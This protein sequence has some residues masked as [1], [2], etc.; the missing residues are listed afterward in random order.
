MYTKIY[1][2]AEDRNDTEALETLKTIGKPPYSRAKSV[3]LLFKVLKKYERANST[4]A[5]SSWFVLSPDYDNNIDGDDYSFVNYVG[6]DK[7]GIQSMIST[8]NLMRN[9][10]DFSEINFFIH[11]FV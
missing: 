5:P 11:I 3:G 2:I 10:L 7:M 6:D 8:I 4:P 1:K 9:N